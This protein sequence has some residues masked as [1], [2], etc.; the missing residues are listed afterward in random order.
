MKLEAK[1]RLLSSWG[2]LVKIPFTE[3]TPS[4]EKVKEM[5]AW[6]KEH[7]DLYKNYY[8]EL[9]HGTD[10]S[11]PILEQ[12]LKPTSATRRRSYQSSNGYVYLAVTPERAK[13]FGDAGNEGHSV[14]Y[15][16]QIPVRTMLPDK[17]QL[18]N[19]RSVGNIPD[20]LSD[21]IAVSIVYAGTV[22]QSKGHK[23]TH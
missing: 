19:H 15:A 13:S 8:V 23:Q 12:G 18:A 9:Y 2:N 11:L 7:S 3:G 14:V 17:D 5:A 20:A 4:P 21:S 22:R 6:I 1:Q 16:V 10:P